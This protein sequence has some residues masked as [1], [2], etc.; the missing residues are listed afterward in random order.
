MKVFIINLKRD[1]EKRNKIKNRLDRLNINY[2]FFEAIDGI[3]TKHNGIYTGWVDSYHNRYVTKGEVGCSLSHYYIWE[4]IITEKIETAIIL[5]DDVDVLDNKFIEKVEN[6]NNNFDLLYLSRKKFTGEI[7]KP[8]NDD[9]VYASPSYWTCAYAVSLSGAKKL[10]NDIFFDNIIPVDEYIPYLYS[11]TY[12]KHLDNVYGELP[13]ITAIAFKNNLLKPEGEAFQVSSTYFSPPCDTVRDDVILITVATD[14]N[15]ALKRYISSCKQFGFNPIILGLGT[16]WGGGDMENGPGGGQKILLLQEYIK[17]LDI[18]ENKLIVFTD[19]YDVICNNNINKLVETYKS[20]F[21]NKIVFASESSCWP[22]KSL[23]KLYA[24]TKRANKYLNSGLFIGYLNDIQNLIIKSIKPYDDDQLYYTLEFL[25]NTDK[26]KLDYENKLFLCLNCDEKYYHINKSTSLLVINSNKN[27]PTFIHGN[28]PPKIKRRLHNIGNY[29]ANY[30]NSTYGYKNIYKLNYLPKITIIFEETNNTC[31]EVIDG[32]CSIDYPREIIQFIYLYTNTPNEEIIKNYKYI[33][34]NDENIILK[35][36]NDEQT[37][38]QT[39]EHIL[40]DKVFY[41]NS[42]C[43]IKNKDIL[44]QLIIENKH[45]IG[46]VLKRPN[47]YFS[48]F[49][50]DLDDNNYYKRSNNYIDILEMREKNCWNVSYLSFCFLINKDLFTIKNLVDNL[51]KGSGHDMALCYN[52]RKMNIFMYALNTH[53]FGYLTDEKIIKKNEEIKLHHY[54]ENKQLWESKYLHNK[55]NTEIIMN[56]IGNNINKVQV[57]SEIFCKEVLEIAN[58]NGNWSKGKDNTYDERIQAKENHPTQDIH[59]K[60]LGLEDMWKWIVDTYISKLVWNKYNYNYKNINIS[61]VVKY[62]M[63]GQRKL[64]PHH[65]S[66]TFTLNLCL[67]SDFDGGG[68]HFI[69]DD[70]KCVNKDIGSIILHPGKLTHYHS[71]MPITDGTRFILVSFI[72]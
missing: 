43:N 51:N 40:G 50:G 47:S 24:N 48:N 70:I 11:N 31:K 33:T 41:I 14:M 54:K 49:W 5:E 64:R 55:F 21:E 65:D 59:L 2:E 63:N 8:F 7:E 69:K 61:F 44:K 25:S 28:G 34:N 57:F 10:K 20:D 71:G 23:E 13:K 35:E 32:L 52:I 66:S 26:I 27:I 37:I 67:N 19:S 18:S 60:E 15:D 9:I 39:I 16:K 46:P 45:F 72:N 56:E 22:D 3:N 36:R 62:D 6:V 1:I 17:T 12:N 42:M 30:Y 4:K 38:L 29:T 58:R 68:C 53:Y